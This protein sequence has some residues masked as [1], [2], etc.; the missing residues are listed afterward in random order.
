MADDQ[1]LRVLDGVSK[2]VVMASDET[3]IRHGEA[4]AVRL[5]DGRLLLLWSELFHR[6]YIPPQ[7]GRMPR[8]TRGHGD[9]SYGRISG[10]ESRDGGITWSEPRVVVDDKDALINCMS[11]GLTRLRDG[12]LLLTY[13][14][15]SG[16]NPGG[17]S[18]VKNGA[19]QKRA[20]YSSDE[21]KTW[22][23]PGIITPDDGLYHTGCH[24]RTYTLPSGRI[25]VQ[26]HSRFPQEGE[27]GLWRR[28]TNWIAYSDDNGRS[29]QPSNRLDEPRSNRGFAEASIARRSDG[30][31]LMLM[32]TTLGQ[33]FCT[34]SR[35]EGATWS[36]P[37]PSGIVAP[38]APSLLARIP[39]TDNLLLVWNPHFN[40]DSGLYGERC[41]LVCAVSRDGGLSWGLPKALETDNRFWWEYPNILFDGDIA[42]LFYR[43]KTRLPEISRHGDRD[44]DMIHARIP[45]AWFYQ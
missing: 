45:V 36:A 29:W 5:N 28:M 41:P 3:A 26:V 34:E 20:R 19:A 17:A 38:A 44:Q 31:L 40:P 15:R 8:G 25:L 1:S 30:S 12:R 11:P 18:A 13:S 14:W 22:S 6:D 2:S 16:G 43:R 10:M 4:T 32:R 39:D 37:R 21:G 27:P 24:D 7:D 23:E 35:D 9:D 42:H 33:A